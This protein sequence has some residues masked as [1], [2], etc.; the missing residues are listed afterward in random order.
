MPESGTPG[1]V[2]SRGDGKKC[3]D[4]SMSVDRVLVEVDNTRW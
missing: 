3:C 1:L 4:M 2:P